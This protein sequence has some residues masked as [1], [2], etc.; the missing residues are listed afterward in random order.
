MRRFILSSL[1]VLSGVSS[2][3]AE[4]ISQTEALEIARDFRYAKSPTRSSDA[5]INFT[6][7]EYKDGVYILN[8]PSGGWVL[9]SMDDRVPE[10][11]L[12]YSFV[13][14]LSANNM[15][16]GISEIV[17][18]YS[19]GIVSMDEENARPC[20]AAT[21]GEKEVKP[22]LGEINWNQ[23]SPYNSLFPLTDNEEKALAG[24]VTVAEG[25]IMCYHQY[26][27]SG[28]GKHSYTWNGNTYSVNFSQSYYDWDLIKPS[29]DGTESKESIEAVSKFLY[30]IAVSNS[31]SFGPMTGAVLWGSPMVEFFDYDPGIIMV[32]RNRCTREYYETLMR[33]ELDSS[34]PVYIQAYNEW[35]GGH[36]FVCDGYNE[37]GYF[38]YNMGG[39][40]GG[41]FLS[42]A[43][44][45]DYNPMM[46]C[47]IKPN[48]GGVPGLWAGSEKEFYW[49]EGDT[50]SCHLRGD[51][52]SAVYSDLEVGL[53]VVNKADGE[54][55]YYVV[56]QDYVFFEVH[57]IDFTMKLP[58]GEYTLYPV[59]HI[60]GQPWEKVC[61]PDYVADH[62]DV[63]V[64]N[65]VKSYTNYNTGGPLA[66]GVFQVDGV[67]YTIQGDEALVSYR[68]LLGNSYSGDVAIPDEIEYE[69]VIYPVA[70]IGEKA[71]I[72][73]RVNSVSVGK[74]VRYIGS[75]AFKDTE[76][77]RI[78][79]ANDSKLTD[80]AYQAFE[81][82]KLDFLRLP[83]GLKNM[84]SL[85]CGDSHIK[86]LELPET[87]ERMN[88]LAVENPYGEMTDV[89]VHWTSSDMLPDAPEG[90]F[91]GNLS[92]ITLHVPK[93][94]TG[95]YQNN[96]A[97]KKFGRIVEDAASEIIDIN[98]G[99]GNSK[100]MVKDG[101]I[102]FESLGED[103]TATVYN[104][105]GIKVA[106]CCAGETIRPGK[107][108]FFVA[109]DNQIVKILL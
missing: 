42:S 20:V 103:I 62:V 8:Y 25:M 4:K 91:R 68:N 28:Q 2:V 66:D 90:T 49:K 101:G 19:L 98:F 55:T 22:L 61:F 86:R 57:D 18:Q 60:V 96:V 94:S 53:A 44:G 23:G 64:K 72:D 59:C 13:G 30:D 24:C 104:V 79:F 109:I 31:S 33:K 85:A 34:R 99:S 84:E 3:M 77:G 43:T 29:Y 71:F 12:G 47:N 65:G 88:E 81:S 17:D 56:S 38:H 82:C 73:S 35:G 15:P 9:V 100:I 52:T 46:I 63:S 7:E 97:W 87:I 10:K 5:L 106:E 67:Y 102:I 6:L 83:Y 11:V 32:Y 92:D 36:A 89:I 41:Y 48:E 58:D 45:W 74:N 93:G 14:H 75:Y 37:E 108:I 27:T 80:L 69:G 21:R 95:I 16:V 78:K 76:I 54:T 40:S 39:G 70:G 26:P 51:I 107:G 1:L 50:L 105:Q